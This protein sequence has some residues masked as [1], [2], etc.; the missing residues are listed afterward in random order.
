MAIHISDD[1]I[2]SGGGVYSPATLVEGGLAWGM[3]M[4]ADLFDCDGDRLDDVEFIARFAVDL[5]DVIGMRR[6]GEP[7]VPVFGLADP[8]T[9]GPSLVQLIETSL[10]SAH[11]ARRWGGGFVA[12]NIHSCKPFDPVEAA[13][14]AKERFD[15]GSMSVRVV[16]RGLQLVMRDVTP[17]DFVA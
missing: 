17:E 4:L 9:A 12:L 8:K 11:F 16:A 10:V 1:L 7:Q 13:E 15:A 14:F 2:G 6:Y 3:E 5:C